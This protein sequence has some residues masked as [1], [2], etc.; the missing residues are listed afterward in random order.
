MR[1]RLRKSFL[2]S[3]AAAGSVLLSPVAASAVQIAGQDFNALSD[4]GGPSTD[5]VTDGGSLTNTNAFNS[6]GPGLDFTAVWNDTRGVTTGPVT[7]TSDSSDF[8]GVSSFGGSNAPDTAA[9][10][11]AVA[12]GVEHN[13][14][15]N[16]TD[17]LV[18]V[19]FEP[20]DT[21]GFTSRTLSFDYWVADTGFESDDAF[22]VTLDDGSSTAT[23]LSFSE[24]ELEGAGTTDGDPSVWASVTFD[25]EAAGL[26]P[27]LSAI[28]AV[29]TNS[30]SEN[31]FID[32]I[33]FDGQAVPAP[34]SLLALA[35]LGLCGL[36]AARRRR[37]R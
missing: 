25:I 26:G 29:D 23:V 27:V 19:A 16:D 31:V 3:A 18:S 32:N 21:T 35:S 7:P 15:F 4:S 2:L 13:Y 5:M 22:V 11:T 33:S 37:R 17:G 10:G 14:Q 34:G 20:V 24:T 36:A 12:S 6:G 8:I 1:N 28:F 30:G 9:D